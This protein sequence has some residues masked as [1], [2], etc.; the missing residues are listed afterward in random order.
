MSDDMTPE[1]A[2]EI[3]DKIT[4]PKGLA[5]VESELRTAIANRRAKITSLQGEIHA[6]D[7]V[8]RM[9]DAL[10]VRWGIPSTSV[11]MGQPGS[12]PSSQAAPP[13]SV[14]TAPSTDDEVK[15]RLKK[16]KCTYKAFKTKKWCQ[17]TLKTKPEKASGYCEIHMRQLGLEK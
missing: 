4:G 14:K 8:L 7:I 6:F 11:P 3:V 12:P 15:E 1:R 10:R 13:P 16:N 2:M 17:R 5:E 9:L